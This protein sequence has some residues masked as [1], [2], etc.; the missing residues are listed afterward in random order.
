MTLTE[1]LQQP[2]QFLLREYSS[3]SVED[4]Q[5][6][7][8]GENGKN[9]IILKGIMQRA[10]SKNGNGRIY[11]RRILEREANRYMKE[12]VSKRNA[13][14]CL[15]H[16]SEAE[17]LLK[18][19]SHIVTDIWWE[20]N[21]MYGAIEILD[22]PNGKIAE[23]YY[24]RKVLLGISTRGVGSISEG[25]DGS[26]VNDDYQL[27]CWDLVQNPSTAG[28]Y[29]LKEGQLIKVDEKNIVTNE[30]KQIFKS[31]SLNKI[32]NIANDILRGK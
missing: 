2:G 16:S 3:F 7:N 10:D 28:A 14:G 20:G 24:N 6:V 13:I 12:F 11:N 17:V 15:D 23:A 22:T 27:I 32:Y 31:N 18:E 9:T 19:G 8:K 5:I 21:D 26:F 4:K 29:M 30:N 25:T 1:R